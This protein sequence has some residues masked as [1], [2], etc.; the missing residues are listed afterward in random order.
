[1]GQ[2]ATGA[3]DIV[4]KNDEVHADEHVDEDDHDAP[5]FTVIFWVL[6]MI[7]AFVLL[8]I[9]AVVKVDKSDC[10]HGTALPGDV[11]APDDPDFGDVISMIYGYVP[12]VIGL[13]V[14]V[15]VFYRKTMWPVL[16]LLLAG[17]IVIINEGFF[18]RVISQDRPDGSCLH[19][20]GMPSSHAE[21]S[22]GFFLYFHLECIFKPALTSTSYWTREHKIIVCGLT[23]FLLLPVP[24]TRVQLEDHSWEQ[25]GVGALIGC[26]VA[27]GWYCLLNFWAYKHLDKVAN[28]IGKCPCCKCCAPLRDG[29]FHGF[30]NDYYPAPPNEYVKKKQIKLRNYQEA[31]ADVSEVQQSPSDVQTPKGKST[32][33]EKAATQSTEQSDEPGAGEQL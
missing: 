11:T 2:Q 1:M 32:L 12:Y 31:Q 19:S 30:T 29:L 10:D 20:K 6:V 14:C 27:V 22:V 13:V 21:L 8:V 25:V 28:L 5:K 17:L 7:A 18:K 4:N 9:Y 24:F 26:S 15:L 3:E 23:W 33:L 16:I